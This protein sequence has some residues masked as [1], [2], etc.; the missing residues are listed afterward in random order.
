MSN[1]Q[2]KPVAKSLNE[3]INDEFRRW[4]EELNE[5]EQKLNE[6]EQKIIK[7]LPIE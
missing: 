6:R 2:Q 4:E 7:N 3:I 5:R 1:K